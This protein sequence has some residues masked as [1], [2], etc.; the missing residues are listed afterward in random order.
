M[1][2]KRL[3]TVQVLGGHASI[4]TTGKYSHLAPD[5][6]KPAVVSL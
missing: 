4:K 2:G 6:L 3:R 1:A 5:Y